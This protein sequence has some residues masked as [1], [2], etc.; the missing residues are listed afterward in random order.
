M[1]DLTADPEIDGEFQV[2]D[3][4][5]IPNYYAIG[6]HYQGGKKAIKAEIL[7]D[8]ENL[9]FQEQGNISLRFIVNCHGETGR[10]RSK[11]TD[12]EM[13][14]IPVDEARL[15]KIKNRVRQ[16]NKWNPAK[17]DHATYDS[18]YVLN[19]KL[20]DGRIVDIF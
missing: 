6:T 16:L 2:C 10:F 14:K 17:N 15:D 7:N 13:K 4:D 11:S 3:E 8:L 1:G 18:Y 9:E 5:K 20:R 19:F 12:L